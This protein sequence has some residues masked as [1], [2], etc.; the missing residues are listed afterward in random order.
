MNLAAH[1]LSPNLYTHRLFAV[2]KTTLFPTLNRKDSCQW[3]FSWCACWICNVRGLSCAYPVV[4]VVCEL[5]GH[6]PYSFA[7]C[8][9]VGGGWGEGSV[10]TTQ[11][12]M[13]WLAES[14]LWA[15]RNS[16]SQL[17]HPDNLAWLIE[18]TLSQWVEYY[19]TGFDFQYEIWN[20]CLPSYSVN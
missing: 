19:S 14:Q 6:L 18:L 20:L 11:L 5:S 10:A 16:I 9:G 3:E 7:H 4:E 8:W 15:S 2:D 1:D 17:S 13:S 12:A